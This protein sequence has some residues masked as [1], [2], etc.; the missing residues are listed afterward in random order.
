MKTAFPM[1]FTACCLIGFPVIAQEPQQPLPVQPPAQSPAAA[2][3][4]QVRAQNESLA[5]LPDPS[6]AQPGATEIE[7]DLAQRLMDM[8]PSIDVNAMQSLFFTKWEHDLIIDARR[9]LN[10]RPPDSEDG[11]AAPAGPREITLGGI[12]FVSK[13]DWTIWLND[14][15]V[16]PNAIPEDVMDLKVYKNYIELEWFDASTNQIF[17]V[18]LRPHQRFNLDT[19]LFLPS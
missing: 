4:E 15:R 3:T 7:K 16:T 5:S 12:V 8:R 11:V 10:T 18:R 19:R 6:V 9:G 2:S 1:L 13:K 14:M 17:P